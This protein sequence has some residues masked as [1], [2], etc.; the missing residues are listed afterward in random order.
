[1]MLSLQ[2]S[3]VLLVVLF[4]IILLYMGNTRPIIIYITGV[5]VLGLFGVISSKEI[6][7][8]FA[9]EQIAIILL[10]IIIG[11]I[12][13][14][15]GI[16]NSAFDLLFKNTVTANVFLPKLMVFVSS[17]SAFFNNAPL[18]AMIIPY[19]DDWAT[20]NN[21]NQSKLLIPLSYAAIL[22]GSATLIGTSTNLLINGM[23]IDAGENSMN[24][25]EFSYVGVPMIITG[26][27]YM[28][29]VGVRLLPNR[30]SPG[31]QFS[32]NKREYMVEVLI[33][34][35]SSFHEKSVEDAGLRNLKD[36]F[37]V[38]IIRRDY[39]IRVTP[40]SI[41]Q[42][43][44]K[45]IFAGDTKEVISLI[46]RFDGLELPKEN[47]LIEKDTVEI[48]EVVV[49][50]NSGLQDAKVK[51]S[52]FRSR[53]DAAIIAVHRNGEHLAGKIGNIVLKAGDVLLLF[54]NKG[55]YTRINGNRD[56]YLISKIK[57]YKHYKNWQRAVLL[58]SLV[59]VI[60][61]SA[62]K[63]IALFKGLLA[64]LVFILIFKIARLTDF[65]NSLDLNLLG[66]AALSLA[67]GKAIMNS[68][69]ADIVAEN[70]IYIL[71]PL[72]MIGLLAG[73][74]IITSLIASYMT[75]ITAVS[76]VFPIAYSIG[77]SLI[78]DGL[79]QSVIPFA[80][81]VAYGASANYVT[82][83]GYLTNIMVYS[84]GSYRF[85]DFL[86]VGLPLMLLHMIIAVSIIYFVYL[87]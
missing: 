1:M 65:K 40:K 15:A 26:I 54:T 4:M 22:G 17:F 14:K 28:L 35:Q 83:V 3:V 49:S 24:I 11:N 79:I 19:I 85:A 52:D 48:V 8:G 38:E 7:L 33:S 74:F 59:G 60:V 5:T 25:F 16:I 42:A 18:V 68:G 32:K 78:A 72:G 64:I 12:V 2:I 31:N 75:N 61:L 27:I 20:K 80:L 73:L 76:I 43:G 30:P 34:E 10:L 86:K 6:L 77:T 46:D 44:D 41:L 69:L 53:F 23:M 87:Y 63:I 21:I 62:L 66:I 29:T 36:L 56:F 39:H 9:N 13:H 57:E 37:L 58:F 70:L 51:L 45:L 82:P 67:L 47:L 50:P 71:H 81:I 55:F 84:S